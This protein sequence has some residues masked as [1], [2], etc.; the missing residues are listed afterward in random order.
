MVENSANHS[1]DVIHHARTRFDSSLFVLLSIFF[2]L[3]QFVNFCSFFKVSISILS[4]E[5]LFKGPGIFVVCMGMLELV[6]TGQS[7]Q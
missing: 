7:L 6:E 2:F 1:S 4:R 3:E 5:N